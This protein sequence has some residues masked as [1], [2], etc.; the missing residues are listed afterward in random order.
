MLRQHHGAT[1]VSSTTPVVVDTIVVPPSEEISIVYVPESKSHPIKAEEVQPTDR[2]EASDNHPVEGLEPSP[3]E[4]VLVNR[5]EYELPS[6]GG[7]SQ[8]PLVGDPI[9]EGEPVISQVPLLLIVNVTEAD[10][11]VMSSAL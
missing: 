4:A 7:L 10:P 6:I 3:E 8:F 2:F 1:R 11:G 5:T 9:T